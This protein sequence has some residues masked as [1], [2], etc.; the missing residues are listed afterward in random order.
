MMLRSRLGGMVL[1]VA[2]VGAMGLLPSLAQEPAKPSEAAAAAKPFRRVPP[3]FAKAGATPDQKAKIYAIRGR[4]QEKIAELRRQIVEAEAAEL[5]ECEAVLM[6]S[7]RKLL[8]QLRGE[9]QAKAKS[10]A[11]SLR[12]AAPAEAA[13]PGE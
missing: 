6:D 2:L 4:H 3:Y 13:K 10:R 11:Q 9:G 1:G 8:A 7:Q 12:A 5:A